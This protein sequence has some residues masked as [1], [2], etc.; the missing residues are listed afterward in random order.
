M[1]TVVGDLTIEPVDPYDDAAVAAWHAVYAEA[2]LDGNEEHATPWQLEEM[3]VLLQD[4]GTRVAVKAWSGF[5]EGQHVAAGFLRMPMQDNLDRCEVAVQVLPDHRR[6]GHGRAL[7][8]RLE[9]EA[10][11]LGR[12]VLYAEISWDVDG[13]SEGTD[14]AGAELARA[15]G[16]GLALRDVQREL[17]LP[18]S[19]DVLSSL[20]EDAAP[21]HAAYTLRSFVGAVPD[22]LVEGWATL[23]ASLS[24]E[25]PS[26]HHPADHLE[27]RGERPHGGRQRADGL[28]PGRSAGGVPEDAGLADRPARHVRIDRSVSRNWSGRATDRPRRPPRLPR[29]TLRVLPACLPVGGEV[30]GPGVGPRLPDGPAVEPPEQS[31]AAPG[32]GAPHA[33]RS[34]ATVLPPDVHVIAVQLEGPT[35]SVS[36]TAVPPSRT[37]PTVPSWSSAPGGVVCGSSVR[38]TSRQP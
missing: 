1:T 4:A 30:M 9:Q 35:P 27:R 3:R 18:V 25:A 14:R 29:P 37:P 23:L 32:E 15:V 31:G 2:E 12:S 36:R 16:F 8:A 17:A 28:P 26:R 21:H 38:R 13:G 34:S 24:T 22:D 7:A 19:A 10:R 5:A 11:A 20:A 33:A 6:R